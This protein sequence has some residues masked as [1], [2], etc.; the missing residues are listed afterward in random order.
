LSGNYTVNQI[1]KMIKSHKTNVKTKFV[2][3]EIMNQLSY[4]VESKKLEKI[5]LK[6]R[7]S[8]KNDIKKTLNL[9]KNLNYK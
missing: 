9:L 7:S 1:I 2:K 8:I 4:H 6:L 5:G 3:S